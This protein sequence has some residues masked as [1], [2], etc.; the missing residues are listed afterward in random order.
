MV[1]QVSK[2]LSKISHQFIKIPNC[3]IGFK[4]TGKRVS[5]NVG[6]GLEIPVQYRFIGAKKAIE[7]V[8]KNIKKVFECI[9]KKANKCVNL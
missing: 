2:N 3:T 8:E 1:G 6:Y 9:N 7:W 4:I 5:R